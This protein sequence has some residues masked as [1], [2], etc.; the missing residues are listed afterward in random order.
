MNFTK[1]FHVL[2]NELQPRQREVLAGRFGIEKSG[3]KLTLAALGARYGVTRERV[4]QIENG[5]LQTLKK[6]VEASPACTDF[7]ARSKKYLKD[8]GGVARYDAYLHFARNIAQGMTEEHLTL[9]IEASR[10]F[11]MHPETRDFYRFY[12]LDKEHLRHATAFIQQFVQFLKGKKD[13]VLEG[14]YQEFFRQFAKQ[15]KTDE[16]RAANYASISK[17]IIRSP[18]GETGLSEWREVNP[19]TIRDRIYLVLRKNS[20]PLHFRTI[21]RTINEVGAGKRK[22]SAPTVHN[23]LIKDERFVLV[24]R[25]IYALRERGYEPGTAREVIARILKRNGSLRPKD[26]VLA[27]QKERFFKPNTIL[28]NLQNRSFFERLPDGKYQI[29]NA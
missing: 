22:A 10:A 24:G 12:Y 13:R 18:Y 16:S 19:R 4:R 11:H 29:R 1:T 26:I 9:L 15:K 21:A 17:R 3:K 20:E 8:S 28:V 7:I 23:E 14:K 27:I 5:G 2:W 6:A 25:G